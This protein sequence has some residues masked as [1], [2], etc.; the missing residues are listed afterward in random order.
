M[1]RRLLFYFLMVWP[2]LDASLANAHEMRPALLQITEQSSQQ[3][4]QTPSAP[5]FHIVWKRPVNAGRTMDISPQFPSHCSQSTHRPD[6]INGKSWVSFYTLTCQHPGLR[7]QTIAIEGLSLTVTDALLRILWLDG[8][9]E[10]HILKPD[11]P[12]VSISGQRQERNSGL[13]SYLW[14]GVEHLLTGFDHV[15]FVVGLLYF[16]HN[17]WQLIKI[18][19]AFT[20]AHSI[21]LGLSALDIVRLA[22]GPV[23]AVIALS[24][25]YLAV[26]ITG[27]K[28]DAL[29][30]RK[31]WIIAFTFGLLHGF[32]F[33][34]AL[35]EIGLPED[36]ILPALFLFNVGIEIGQL[37][38]VLPVVL[39]LGMLRTRQLMP[40]AMVVSLPAWMIGILSSYWLIDRISTTLS[41]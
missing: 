26:E 4:S 25:L 31:P 35:R 17:T 40:P 16:G 5:L 27:D 14:L 19:T 9:E 11:E 30:F 33:A 38:I 41:G 28:K 1:T 13:L 7:Q 36:A 8:A 2:L 32:G 10:N 12:F 24:I 29:L 37:M 22:Q 34:G 21:T 15:L 20:L 3:G 18:V 23:E 39:L 6:Q